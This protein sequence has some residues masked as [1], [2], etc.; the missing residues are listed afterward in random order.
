MNMDMFRLFLLRAEEVGREEK[1]EDKK[2]WDNEEGKGTAACA[3]SLSLSLFFFF[4][5]F[6]FRA[7]KRGLFVFLSLFLF[8]SLP[9][10]FQL[11][12]NPCEGVSFIPRGVA[13]GV[14][15][16]RGERKSARERERGAW[17]ILIELTRVCSRCR[18]R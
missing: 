2:G 9:L 10:D 4:F 8:I 1:V 7:K 16:P 13:G 5:L 17:S 12:M 6:S 15:H 3:R 14:L 11:E 18:R